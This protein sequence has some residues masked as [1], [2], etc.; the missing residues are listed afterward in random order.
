MRAAHRLPGAAAGGLSS[1]SHFR[2]GEE[3]ETAIWLNGLR[4]LDPFHIRDYH[5][6]FSSI[7]ANAIAGMEAYTGGFPADYGDRTS[8]LLLLQ[9]ERP[10]EP[11]RTELGLGVYNTSALTT[12]YTEDARFEWLAS[13]RR[14]NLDLVLSDD[15]GKPDYSDAFSELAWNPS[16]TTRLALNALYADDSVVV[17]TESEPDELEQTR[18]DT[19]NTH[20]WLKLDHQHGPRLESSTVLAWSQLDATRNAVSM[21]EEQLVADVRDVRDVEVYGLRQ[22]WRWD[23]SDAH[24]LRFGFEA[25]HQQARYDYH[26][27]AEYFG[28]YA[29]YPTTP[30]ELVRVVRASPEGERYAVFLADR[31]RIGD[32]TTLDAGLRW[33]RQTWT[34]PRFDDQ[35]SPRLSLRHEL[36]DATQLRLSWGRYHQSEGI[37]QLQVEDGLD[38]FF[39]PQEADHLIAALHHR[40]GKGLRLRVE[41][42]RK[43]YDEL[44]PRFENLLDP[45]PLIP[46]LEPDRVRLDPSSARAEGVELTL[47]RRGEGPL[48]WW[49]HYAWSSANDTI[50]GERQPRSWD[51]RHA[52]QAGAAL[53]RGP[54]S[55]GA[56]FGVHSG[57]PTTDVFLVDEVP[58]FGPR[59]AAQLGTFYT[60]DFRIARRFDVRIGEL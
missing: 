27:V 30:D 7:D 52:F 10:D 18:S 26:A 17:T 31:W 15:V 34:E 38:R 60:L 33:D 48:E 57:W 1:R 19:R 50:D 45:I 23:A 59:N 29:L 35:W 36:S 32:A 56:A 8:G 46:E 54:W 39:A 40:F 25:D 37:H 2:G 16:D 13:A 21:D 43:D 44:R 4:L 28:F 58:L 6:I 42:Y 20:L 14:S 55:F 5:S 41:V 22:E 12:G 47:D 24:A 3:N 49:A 11:R 53:E 9:S 51:Q